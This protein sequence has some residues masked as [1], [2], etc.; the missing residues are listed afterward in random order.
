MDQWIAVR[1]MFG[2]KLHL[3]DQSVTLH[4]HCALIG[5]E[6]VEGSDF[7]VFRSRLKAGKTLLDVFVYLL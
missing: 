2:S 3:L 4:A 5:S 6:K 7:A 1:F